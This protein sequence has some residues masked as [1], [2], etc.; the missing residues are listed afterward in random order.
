MISALSNFVTLQQFNRIGL[1]IGR[2]ASVAPNSKARI[3]AYQLELDFG[4]ALSSE[5]HSLHGKE[6]YTSSAQ[7]CSNHSVEE[8]T[9]QLLLCVFNFPRKQI[10]KMMSDCL[11]TGVQKNLE[12]PDEKRATTV[13]MR[14]S[15]KV[16]LGSKI[17]LLAESTIHSSNT[18]DLMWDEFTQLDLRIGTIV[19]RPKSIKS[20]SCP[21]S[22]DQIES[23][24]MQIDLG[25]EGIK[26]AVGFFG[27]ELVQ[28]DLLGHQVMV[29]TNL[30]PL[31]I[32]EFSGDTSATIVICTV[33]GRALI[34]PA[35]KVE[36]GYKLA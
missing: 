8:I 21:I 35:K 1:I 2:A 23:R 27:Q 20:T 33:A 4:A 14:P 34:E 26:E 25:S 13:F 15:S 24:H 30:S 32:R 5:H 28:K 9:G 18:R 11:V 36:N 31:E 12:N 17:G 6:R 19:S 10:G 29:L 3:P 16:P 22:S 7:L